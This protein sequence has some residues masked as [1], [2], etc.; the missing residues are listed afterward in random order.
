[1]KKL[2]VMIMLCLWCSCS[3]VLGNS[4]TA[5]IE[6]D[7]DVLS[8]LELAHALVMY[9][10]DE[11]ILPPAYETMK[12]DVQYDMCLKVLPE[13]VKFYLGAMNSEDAVT[14]GLLLKVLYS[15]FSPFTKPDH[16]PYPIKALQDDKQLS[17][18]VLSQAVVTPNMIKM[19]LS[20]V[21]CF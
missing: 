13:S 1:M 10:G 12:P 5:S 16:I 3:L 19:V 15:Y 20:R 6:Q 9:I 7:G 18:S 4:E 8:C 11:S 17:N 21:F 14:E 2:L